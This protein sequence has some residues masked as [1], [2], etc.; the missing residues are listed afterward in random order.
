MTDSQNPTR[1]LFLDDEPAVLNS[2]RRSLR[3]E[4]YQ[5]FLSTEVD[6]ALRIIHE[7]KIDIVVSD[8][9]MPNMTGAEFFALAARLHPHVL[10]IMLT[11]QADVDVAIRS[12]NEGHVHRFLTKPWDDAQLKFILKDAARQIEN[13][14]Q[15]E[16]QPLRTERAR[17]RSIQRDAAGAIVLDLAETQAV[18]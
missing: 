14:R 5:I 17:L 6:D 2:L 10:R 3:K 4:G 18:H 11:G 1:I 13:R 16:A 7:E 12:I 8:H 15:A 9:L